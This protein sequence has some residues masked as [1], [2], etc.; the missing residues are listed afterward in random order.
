M[1]KSIESLNN[2]LKQLSLGKAPVKDAAEFTTKIVSTAQAENKVVPKVLP[3]LVE[4]V[5]V[6]EVFPGIQC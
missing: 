5:S 6:S 2:C 4:L 1:S 3:S